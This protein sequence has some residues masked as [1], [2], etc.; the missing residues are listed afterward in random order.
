MT[1]FR[2]WLAVALAAGCVASVESAPQAQWRRLDSPNFIVIGEAGASDLRDIA[3]KFEGFREMLGRVLGGKVTSNVVPTVVTVFAHDRTFT[4]FKP[5]HEGKRV[6][7]AGLFV[8]GRDVNHIL[9]IGDDNPFRLRLI[10]HEYAHLIVSNTG[11]RMPPWLGEGLA[12]YYSTFELGK[13]GREAMLGGLIEEHLALLND[14]TMLTV[15]EL[16]NVTHDSPLYN[17]STR[18]GVFYAQSW[19]LTHMIML[20]EPNRSAQLSAYLNYL[21]SGAAPVDAWQRAFGAEDIGKAL[22]AYVRR[23]LFRAYAFKFSDGLAKFEAQTTTLS[24]A[25]TQAWL[26]DVLVE[27]DDHAEAANRLA[28]ARKTDPGNARAH[29]VNARLSL[30]TGKLDDAEAALKSAGAPDD[31]Y[32]NYLAGVA[33]ADLTERRRIDPAG[34]PLARARTFFSKAS[35][36]HP[37]LPNAAARLAGMELLAG[38]KPSAETRAAAERAH[39]QAPGRHDYTFLLAQVLAMQSEFEAAR[40]MLGPM[41][42][43]AYPA[44]VRDSVR[45]YLGL[46]AS[47]ENT[48]AQRRA[49]SGGGLG[50]ATT[51]T[52]IPAEPEPVTRPVFRDLKPGEQRLEGTLERIECAAGG[53]AV[54]H[55]KSGAAIV[56]ASAPKMAEVEFITYRDDLKG[57]VSCGPVT[58]PLAV[59]V[60]WRPGTTEGNKVVIAVEFLP[61]VK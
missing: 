26:A 44:S 39:A 51:V 20:G 12:E 32:L 7:L 21:S 18:R 53:S 16:L 52:T 57:N 10:F 48:N 58:P 56:T 31:W 34:A 49:P 43:P 45:R 33:V 29:L 55:V 15:P 8:P 2:R 61:R 37:E 24:P 30:A 59:Y 27:L 14:R 25:E 46:I 11:Q 47:I 6:D 9:M 54:F 28:I 35:A 19:A 4:P 36:G 60:T 17:E 41:L 23:Q 5:L 3:V 42:T 1:Q 40:S 22:T 50:L 38:G 13:G